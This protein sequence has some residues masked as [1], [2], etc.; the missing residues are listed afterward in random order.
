M[1]KLRPR[2]ITNSCHL[3]TKSQVLYFNLD[4]LAPH[5]MFM[6]VGGKWVINVPEVLP[7]SLPDTGQGSW[8][9]APK[10][11]RQCWL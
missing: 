1:K 11:P 8:A 9:L 6:K 4:L 10:D 3:V 2:E 5:P 7:Q